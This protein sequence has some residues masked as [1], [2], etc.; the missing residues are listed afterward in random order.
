MPKSGPKDGAK[1]APKTLLDSID[2]LIERYHL[3]KH[4]FY[5]AW[6]EGTLSKEALQL[7]AAQYYQHVRAFP[8]NLKQLASRTN[9]DGNLK[10]IVREN[11]NEE[12]D[13]SAP[14]PQLWR[15]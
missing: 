14:H 15:Q 3:L 11:L 12:L 13:A 4:P 9:G 10:S 8:E 1:N 6:T 5:Q 7:Y 2:T